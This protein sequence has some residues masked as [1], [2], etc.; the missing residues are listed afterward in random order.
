MSQ[1]WL[2]LLLV[3]CGFLG[4]AV[5][6]ASASPSPAVEVMVDGEALGRT[7]AGFQVP[8]S[9]K[10]VSF[11]LGMRAENGDH[12]GRRFRFK[13]ESV[14]NAWRQIP[15]EMSLSLAFND[16][17]GDQVGQHRFRVVGT[18]EG[19]KERIEN[20]RFTPRR[21]W[22]RVPPE[23]AF[24]TAI[25]SSS[26]PPTAVGVYVVRDL[27]IFRAGAD[28]QE[29]IFAMTSTGNRAESIPEG[30]RRSGTRPSMAKTVHTDPGNAVCIVD[31]DPNAH[32]EWQFTRTATP[33]VQPGELLTVEW[34]E[35]Y[36][37]GEGSRFNVNYGRLNAGV[38]RFFTIAEDATGAPLASASSMEF[39]VQQPF[40]KSAW[41]LCAATA[42]IASLLWLG[43][44]MIMQRE[45]RQHLA[46]AE[47]EHWIERE[48]LRIARDLHDD[49][50]ARL[51][52]ISLMSSLAEN[53]PQ[54]ASARESFQRIS[55]MAREL[56]AALYQTVWTVNPE[57]DHLDALVN[58]VCQLT[59]NLCETARIRCRIHSCEVASER[60]V[61]SEIRHNVTLAVKEALHNA[62]KHAGATE[63]TV[64][65][66]FTDPCLGITIMDNGRGFDSAAA[67]AGNGLGNMRRRMTSL[68]GTLSIESSPET[69]TTV[70][71]DVPILVSDS[72]SPSIPR[73]T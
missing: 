8:A 67:L 69:G 11:R 59:Q 20:S 6:T 5:I 50:G 33:A 10:S 47:Q 55:G 14:D 25:I 22:V 30:W 68:G 65:M 3:V 37:I 34:A 61:T 13:L 46:R 53:D 39:V 12:D 42:A 40:W 15:S 54:S 4:T 24:V 36:N 31:D 38:Y 26:G 52:H 45:I 51:T 70:G 48:R 71:F 58:Y 63:I 44:R 73:A 18:S 1:K 62:I 41:F 56:V 21:E 35:M 32:A 29:Q 16:S 19:W 28:G 49:L 7:A 64:R 66:Q 9:H 23:S 17:A 57:H 2:G 27:K 43:F 72:S 60:R